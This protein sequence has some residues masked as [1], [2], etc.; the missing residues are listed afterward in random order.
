MGRGRQKAKQIKVARE[1]KY[2]V[3]NTDYRVLSEELH[4]AF[5]RDHTFNADKDSMH[6]SDHLQSK[7]EDKNYLQEQ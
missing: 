2:H 4:T 1:L 3:H 7:D 6:E 5:V